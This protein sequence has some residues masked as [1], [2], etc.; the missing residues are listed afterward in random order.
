LL[1]GLGGDLFGQQR[2]EEVRVG[3]LLGRRVLEHGFQ[4]L[5][6]LEQSQPL[7]VLLEA[8]ELRGAHADTGARPRAS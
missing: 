1:G 2:V 8:L 5:A 4:P 6:A 7:H 3:G